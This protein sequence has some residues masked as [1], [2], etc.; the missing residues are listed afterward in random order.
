MSKRGKSDVGSFI[1]YDEGTGL[2]VARIAYEERAYA[3]GAGFM[4]SRERRRWETADVAPVE[5]APFEK[6]AKA[7]ARLQSLA[8][9]IEFAIEQSY[10][11]GSDFDLPVPDGL[12]YLPY[13]RAGIEYAVQR[14]ACLIG[15]D[16]GLGKGHPL[17]FAVCT[18]DGLRQIGDL[19]V[20]DAITGSDGRPTVVTAIH[21]RGM[22]AVYDVTFSDGVTVPVDLDHLWKVR[23]GDDLD[24]QV[25]PTREIMERMESGHRFSIPLMSGATQ[26]NAIDPGIDPRSMAVH[27]SHPGTFAEP[28]DMIPIEDLLTAPASVRESFLATYLKKRGRVS[29]DGTVEILVPVHLDLCEHFAELV[30]SVGG[31]CIARPYYFKSQRFEVVL[32]P[33]RIRDIFGM[34][35][36][37]YND[38]R[39]LK[40][41]RTERDLP[42]REIV[43][44]SLRSRELVRC[45]S[46]AARDRLYVVDGHVVTHN[47]VEAIGVANYYGSDAIKR[48]LVLAPA[49]L[50]VNW[51]REW[52]KWSTLGLT[53]GI[54]GTFPESY[55]NAEGKR[56][57]KMVPYWPDTDVVILNYDQLARFTEQVHAVHWDLLICDE[58]HVLKNEDAGRT[59]E[60]FGFW[61]RKLKAQVP[62]IHWRFALFLTGTPIMNRPAD[63]WTL[64]K[65]CDPDGLGRDWK[66][67]AY[68]YCG[69]HIGYHG[70]EAIGATNLDE[71]HDK[72]RARIMVRRLKKDVLK[73][74]PPKSRHVIVLPA[75]GLQKKITAEMDAVEQA[76]A[77]YEAE[78]GIRPEGDLDI[79]V[80]ETLVSKFR[81]ADFDAYAED[82]ESSGDVASV[83]IRDLAVARRDLALMK[84]PMIVEHVKRVL[85]TE[86]KLIVFAW[87]KAV[88]E[89]LREAFPG[90]ATIAG[91]ISSAVR[92]DGTSARQDQ[93]DRFQTDPD[94]RVFVGQIQAAGVGA[95][96]TAA[97]VVVFAE[98]DW[99][100]G[101]VTQAE[102]RAW[103][104][105]Q[106]DHVLIQHLVVEDSL[107]DRVVKSLITKQAIAGEGLD[108]RSMENDR[109]DPSSDPQPDL[110]HESG[111]GGAAPSPRQDT[112]SGARDDRH[113]EQAHQACQARRE[114][115]GPHRW[116]VALDPSATREGS[117][118]PLRRP[119]RARVGR[120]DRPTFCRPLPSEKLTS[121][122]SSLTNAKESTDAA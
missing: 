62:G 50:K 95:T 104:L 122:P 114:A 82:L 103:R 54:A 27:Y 46:V 42:R 113:E 78:M 118:A 99:R 10:A 52:Q 38:R 13:Q 110:F 25:L 16:M 4:W 70:F 43:S 34:H 84:V 2:F 101:M 33:E 121:D 30:R 76:L 93:I 67:F 106:T 26:L 98:L 11:P 3:Q 21:D 48:V 29:A 32:P 45:I 66:Q 119:H 41:I 31:L 87:H 59:Q 7:K 65:S 111:V 39:V 73:E 53:V 22:L 14:K 96:L 120:L 6:D 86:D 72:L 51:A 90:C 117:Q 35:R 15:D 92:R 69:G 40:M 108:R 81:T 60:V 75:D 71:L 74:L 37:V 18:P 44:I 47:T 57:V 12:S 109:P 102:D 8:D 83:P 20:G 24:W 28:P 85:E 79:D 23:V 56:R 61:S 97:R 105:G 107:D 58:A 36:P 94:C 64:V 116:I 112:G 68:R 91:D 1:T 63:I 49:T 19:S 115:L 80:L 88:V 89:A 55:K 5:I 9:D 17:W 77:L 100:P